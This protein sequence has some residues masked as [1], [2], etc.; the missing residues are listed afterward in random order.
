MEDITIDHMTG[1]EVT[2]CFEWAKAEGWNPGLHDADVFHRT[3]PNGFFAAR[4]NGEMVGGISIVSYPSGFH[5]GG[6]LIVRPDFR[7]KGVGNLLIAHMLQ[8]SVD[9]NLG[10][11]GVI[12]MAKKYESYGFIPAH[13]NVR[14][15]GKYFPRPSRRQDLVPISSVPMRKL[16]EYDARMFPSEREKFLE[17]WTGQPDSFGLACE[18]DGQIK[19]YGI[20]RRCS[21][22]HK[23]GPL[24]ADDE[25]IA[26]D[27]LSSLVSRFPDEEFSLDVPLPNRQAVDLAL[28]F[29]M[30]EAFSTMRM[31]TR[32]VPD[33][34]IDHVFGITSFELG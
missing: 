25:V 5:F 34:D 8:H 13:R 10:C 26:E 7:N 24:F 4:K 30:K 16:I 31:Y 27:I 3:D 6:L 23:V 12:H 22:G 11:D 32:E 17:L 9:H 2:V 21:I 20:I 15:L 1:K 19:G 14:Y 18:E 33:I 29:R 28:R